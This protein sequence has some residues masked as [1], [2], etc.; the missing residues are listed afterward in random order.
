MYFRTKR[1]TGLLAVMLVVLSAVA[2]GQIQIAPSS[3]QDWQE[4]TTTGGTVGF[5]LDPTAPAGNGALS[6][7]TIN[8]NNSRAQYYRDVNVPLSGITQL[9][10]WSKT[11]LGIP[12]AAPSYAIGIWLDGTPATFTNLVFE[13]YW[14]D[15]AGDPAPIVPG[16]W[17]NWDVAA[18]Q[19]FWSS[20][21][22]NAGGACVVTAGGGGPPFYSFADIKANCPNAV[23]VR[24]TVYMG[25]FNPNWN[26]YVDLVNFN[27]TVWDFNLETMVDDDGFASATD[28][29]AADIAS[30]TINAAITAAAPG[31]II[32]VCP[33]TYPE[34]IINGTK[35]ITLLGANAGISANPAHGGVR[36][37]ESL[38]QGTVFVSG[39]PAM[40]IDGFSIQ[41]PVTGVAL[42]RR[43]VRVRG[44]N[45]RVA[46]NIITTLNGSGTGPGDATYGIFAEGGPSGVPAN[47][48]LVNNHIS[49]AYRG[50]GIEGNFAD[51]NLSMTDS[52]ITG[53]HIT[54]IGFTAIY[55]TL[56]ATSGLTQTIHIDNN[57]LTNNFVGIWVVGG[58][59]F[60]ITGNRIFNNSNHGIRIGNAA[61]V[62]L[63]INAT[64][65][66]ITG[67]PV[68]VQF[69]G[70]GSTTNVNFAFNRIAGNTT[71]LSFGRAGSVNAENNWWGCNYGPGA[72]GAGCVGTQ[73][74][75]GGANAALVDA[76]PWLQLTTAASASPILIG[77][78]S[79]ITSQITTNSDNNTPSGGALPNFMTAAFAGTFG[80]V[81]PPTNTLTAGM[82]GTV[83]T[84][85]AQGVGG[86]D[87]TVDNQTVGA[88]IIIYPATCAEL[89]MP[90]LTTLT[91]VPITVPV[92]TTEMTGRNA[93]SA[94]FTVTYNPAVLTFGSV[95]LGPVGAGRVLTVNQP[96]LGTVIISVFG[97]TEFTGN[98][99]LVN[100]NFTNV[101]GL[102][103][104]VSPM[105]F[106]SFMY[107]EGTPCNATTNGSVTVIGG[108][109]TGNVTYGNALVGPA[110]PRYINNVTISGAGAPP[111]FTT[112]DTNGNY[113]L[114]G[115]GPGS[116]T[117]S[118]SKTGGI[119]SGSISAYDSSLIAQ[120]VV[121]LITLLPNQQIVADVSGAGGITSFDAALIARYTVLLPDFGNTGNWIFS[122]TSY[123]P[124]TVYTNLTENYVGLLMGDVSGNWNQ[125]ASE[126]GGLWD[127]QGGR[128][129]EARR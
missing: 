80:T 100:L 128:N 90:N 94:D 42:D 17:Q 76:D 29:D 89:S 99:A 101:Q 66:S 25:S 31:E 97:P 64:G 121:M 59:H 81:A 57:T 110:P 8:D 32:K 20:Q 115:F 92:N 19:Y 27:G 5:A 46:N 52:F 53:N 125:L 33:G 7:T 117:R 122:P 126:P 72:T 87:T 123:G 70:T 118:A 91:G 69:N 113:S 39:T 108:T 71:G 21:T 54:G 82:T 3:Q 6:L 120:H 84:A 15:G 14:S 58:G 38:I 98:G 96:V 78:N 49:A 74:G 51:Y 4:F 109:I 26:T 11:N 10:Y 124:S 37:P 105:N 41:A 102:P 45:K 56:N 112:T 67:N 104:D 61:E 63:N 50:V 22:R 86:V 85:T 111:V 127:P 119:P 48:N 65:N 106:S 43:A 62:I 18:G 77:Q 107:N 16:T 114:S 28:C 88:Q 75:I 55:N 36:G 68:G 47:F 116:Y 2:F 30:T 44:S 83:F 60:S 34:S 95:T 40:N 129:D 13:P 9:S 103:F 73:N 1:L 93:I 24:H 23:V 79:T 35:A 12:E